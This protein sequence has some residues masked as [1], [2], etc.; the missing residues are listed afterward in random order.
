VR[1]RLRH[2]T[3]GVAIYGAGDAA[4]TLVNLFL[5][6][7]YIKGDFLSQ[8]D[9]GALLIILSIETFAKV[10]SRWGLDGAFMRFY[11]D[12]ED[13]APRQRMAS[14]ILWFVLG[15]DAILL[16]VALLASRWVAGRLFEDPDNLVA[17]RLM[18]VN[19]FLMSLTFAPFHSMR[20]RDQAATYSA[21]SFAR[22]VG[23]LA[24]RVLFVIVAG[25][26][27]TGMYLADLVLTL[28]I[29]PVLLPWF[30]PLLRPVFSRDELRASLRFGLPR[31][32]HG[33]AQQALDGG[34]RLLFA[35]YSM[36]DDL[37]VYQ[38]GVTLGAAV[39]FFTSA[40]ETAW[41]PFYYATARQ[42]DARLVFAK[43]TTYSVAVLALLVAGTTAISHDAVLVMAKADYLGAVRVVPIIALGMALQGVYLLTSIGLNLT[44]R[45]EFYPV[46][47]F[48]AAAVGLGSGVF[49]MPRYGLTGAAVAALL[50]YATQACVAFVFAHRF[51]P[52]RYEVGRLAR[53]ALAALLAALVA[54]RLTPPLSPIPE[55]LVRGT[56]TVAV[57]TG[58]LWLSGFFR[59][60][61]RAFLRE[62]MTRLRRRT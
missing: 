21:F 49:L 52:I 54:M 22:S 9:L 58:L 12:R 56:T 23:T 61:E 24:L 44:N 50:S 32:P 47:T 15:A 40:F 33:L 14:T 62:V 51:Y 27:V 34:N 38:A 7:V 3:K 55:L 13:G 19:T 57:Y 5:Y 29:L 8:Q 43:M 36:Q 11:L 37:G 1:D 39:K 20:M 46:S 60:T 26:H 42:S 53:I 35:R 45:T 25:L 6:P 10:I 4:V 16:A 28:L 30:R 17:L 48:A 31:L 18:L 2:L 59:P 41:A